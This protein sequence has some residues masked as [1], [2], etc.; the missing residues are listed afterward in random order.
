MSEKSWLPIQRQQAKAYPNVGFE[1]WNDLP[2]FPFL[3]DYI[4]SLEKTFSP[5]FATEFFDNF[6]HYSIYISFF[7]LASCYFGTKYMKNRTAFDLRKP[8]IIWN[9]LLAVFSICSAFRTTPAFINVFKWHGV[10]GTLCASYYYHSNPEGFWVFLF[11]LS[12]VPEL[13]DTFFIIARKRKLIFLHWYHH[14]TVLMY[15]FYLYRDRLAGGAYYGAM[16]YFVHA[17]M[18]SYYF[19]SACRVRVPKP[20]AMIVTTLQT[21]QMFI[22]V[23]VT[24][25]LWTQLNNPD[26]PIHLGNVLAASA[27]YST[28]LYLFGEF[29][30]NAY[31]KRKTKK[32]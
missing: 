2:K 18:Y 24:C 27:M 12:K 31:F 28:Y 4:V 17:I 29:F 30:I 8:M 22:G 16:N 9:F 1:T 19:L 32:D 21:L 14:F 23:G 5:K 20:I 6:W 7:Y 13:V 3:N 10:E 25:Y 11:V 15:S 26:C